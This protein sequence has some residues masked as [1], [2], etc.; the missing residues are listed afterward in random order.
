MRP[1]DGSALCPAWGTK[2]NKSP[3]RSPSPDGEAPTLLEDSGAASQG[4]DLISRV[5]GAAI[6]RRG[7]PGRDKAIWGKG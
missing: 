5:S 3:G 7:W 2:C 4:G 6:R 1:T